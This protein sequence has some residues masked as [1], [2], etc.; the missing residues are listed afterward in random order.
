MDFSKSLHG[1]VKVDVFFWVVKCIC[2]SCWHG[3]VK[4][5]TWICQSCSIDFSPFAKQNQSEVWPRFQSSLKLCFKLKV[6]HYSKY[7]ILSWCL[8][9]SLSLRVVLLI[10]RCSWY[11]HVPDWQP[12]R[13]CR[14]LLLESSVKCGQ[15]V[16]HLS[17]LVMIMMDNFIIHNDGCPPSEELGDDD[18]GYAVVV[19][20]KND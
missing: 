17:K 18:H 10:K 6:L 13:V 8:T 5:V 1:F 2:H 7:S 3:F 12:I 11:L 19:M 9:L 4:V 16:L 15:D 14:L 20:V